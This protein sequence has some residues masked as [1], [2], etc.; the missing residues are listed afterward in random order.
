MEILK[1][2]TNATVVDILRSLNV[3]VRFI[4]PDGKLLFENE[5][6]VTIK[7]PGEN[8]YWVYVRNDLPVA[9]Q[10]KTLCHELGHIVLGHMT[11]KKFPFM[12]EAQRENE[13]R[14]FASFILPYI[15]KPDFRDNF[16][17]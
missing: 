2:S 14:E 4:E 9:K 12:S 13:A 15:Y 5:Y 17:G 8:K 16:N 10:Q 11:D 3:P 6:G 1:L 7:V